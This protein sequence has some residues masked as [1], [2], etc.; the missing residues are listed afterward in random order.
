[1]FYCYHV[2]HKI[3]ST[4]FSVAV[5]FVKEFVRTDEREAAFCSWCLFKCNFN[6]TACSV[7][8][9]HMQSLSLTFPSP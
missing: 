2:M 9:K 5:C 4:F 1:M 7:V 6:V 8:I 3:T